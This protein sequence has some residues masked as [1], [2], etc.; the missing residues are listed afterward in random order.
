M[1]DRGFMVGLF[2][3]LGMAAFSLF[4][5]FGSLFLLA[6]AIYQVFGG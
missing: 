2:V 5:V 6:A 1:S 4:G 3:I